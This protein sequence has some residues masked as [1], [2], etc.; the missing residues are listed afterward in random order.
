MV[1][2]LFDKWGGQ[3]LFLNLLFKN[4]LLKQIWL[5]LHRDVCASSEVCSCRQG[6]AQPEDYISRLPL[7]LGGTVW[8]VLDRGARQGRVGE[9]VHMYV[10]HSGWRVP[11]PPS[12]LPLDLDPQGDF[13]HGRGLQQLGFLNDCVN[14]VWFPPPCDHPNEQNQQHL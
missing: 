6:A 2:Y 9:R 10:S 7:C 3:A 14:Q 8:L 1:F 13:E 5:R 4:R 11:S 12:L